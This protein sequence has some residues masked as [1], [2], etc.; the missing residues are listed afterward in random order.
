MVQ[1]GN[2]LAGSTAIQHQVVVQ[3]FFLAVVIQLNE[4]LARVRHEFAAC[5][6][7]VHS[8]D[9]DVISDGQHVLHRLKAGA[10][11]QDQ[12]RLFAFQLNQLQRSGG[13]QLRFRMNVD[14]VGTGFCDPLD[15]AVRVHDHHVAVNQLVMARVGDAADHFQLTHRHAEVRYKCAIHDVHMVDVHVRCIQLFDLF[16][17]VVCGKIED[18]RA[19]DLFL[20]GIHFVKSSIFYTC[21]SVQSLR[22]SQIVY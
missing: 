6:A 5:K 10:G 11:V 9:H 20:Q 7:W 17:H 1:V 2:H 12:A 18:R 15:V 13:D 8:H 21:L 16:P 22:F 14:D 19:K 3:A 4:F